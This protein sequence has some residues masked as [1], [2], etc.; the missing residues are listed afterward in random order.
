[1]TIRR[2]A[3][4]SI[5]FFFGFVIT[6][7]PT[8]TV[9]ASDYRRCGRVYAG[10]MGSDFWYN[11]DC[12]NVSFSVEA[13]GAKSTI[14]LP[15]L[16]VDRAT[17]IMPKQALSYTPIVI[18]P[19]WDSS[20]VGHSVDQT[21]YYKI[22]DNNEYR[23]VTL[24]IQAAPA[25]LA[26]GLGGQPFLDQIITY[27]TDSPGDPTVYRGNNIIEDMRFM[28]SPA[29][30]LSSNYGGLLDP[31]CGFVTPDDT[32]ASDGMG[33]PDLILNA[34]GCSV[35]CTPEWNEF[36]GEY[37]CKNGPTFVNPGMLFESMPMFTEGVWSWTDPLTLPSP[38]FS[39]IYPDVSSLKG[40]WG[41]L[42]S[43]TSQP[44]VGFMAQNGWLFRIYVL[45][46]KW[47]KVW[48]TRTLCGWTDTYEPNGVPC[49]PY[50]QSRRGFYYE[51][52]EPYFVWWLDGINMDL[53]GFNGGFAADGEGNSW[54]INQMI[55][56][57]SPTTYLTIP[58]YQALPILVP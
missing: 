22:D 47:H 21:G 44:A 41:Q 25:R 5:V 15:K 18:S 40:S 53:P 48:L 50:S 13:F 29:W 42:D 9:S 34:I 55:V 7:S 23:N 39:Y 6:L 45:G 12:D 27:S 24:Y 20:N 26:G 19:K 3:I 51:Y 38:V 17:D 30:N 8:S 32:F 31:S 52:T 14:Y 37:I 49:N 36:Y 58:V 16:K 10:W 54:L 2:L 11:Y 43:S 35:Y 46:Q 1:M 28:L 57:G 56:D 33:D 4:T